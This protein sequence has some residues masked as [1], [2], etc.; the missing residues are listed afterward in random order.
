MALPV[1]DLQSY[2]QTALARFEPLFWGART[3]TSV[4]VLIP[5]GAEVGVLLTLVCVTLLWLRARREARKFREELASVLSVRNTVES[6]DR[7]NAEFIA[8]MIHRIRTPMNAIVGFI[9]L[10]L[11]TDLDPELREHLDAARTSADW[12]MHIENDALEFSCIE[13]DGLPLDN[14]PFSIS[15][16]ILSIR[17][18]HLE[19]RSR[20]EH[21]SLS[22]CAQI[23]PKAIGIPLWKEIF[24]FAMRMLPNRN[25]A[26]QQAPALLRQREQAAASVRRVRRNFYQ[27]SPL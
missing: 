15:E 6:A 16:C 14:V 11:K 8:S 9:D 13:A 1:A 12:L 25:G 19:C 27:T 4:P 18:I 20:S 21:R 3:W 5:A 26:R 10:A 24:H 2:G 23:V 22:Q 7:A 17:G